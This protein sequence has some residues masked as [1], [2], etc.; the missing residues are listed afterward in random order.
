MQGEC[1]SHCRNEGTSTETPNCSRKY[2]I[3]KDELQGAPLMKAK[4]LDVYSGV[5]TRIGKFP[6]KLYRCQLKENA[7]PTRH[8][9]RKVSIHP[10]DA[11]YEEIRNLEQPG[12]LEPVKEVTEW[13]NSF[14]IVEKKVPIDSS[15]FHL[16]GHRVKKKLQICD[17]YCVPKLRTY[18]LEIV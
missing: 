15:N 17:R 6:G 9:P 3:V 5:F 16:P 12:I 11:F 7:K 1:D 8:T 2:S 4:I 13:V 14:V 18:L 10:Q